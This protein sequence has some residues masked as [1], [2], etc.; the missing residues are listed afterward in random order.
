MNNN[1]RNLGQKSTPDGLTLRRKA[2]AIAVA[3]FVTLSAGPVY[4]ADDQALEDLQKVLQELKAENANLK[5]KLE[6]QTL[7][8]AASSASAETKAAPAD[9]N[10]KAAATE[11]SSILDAVVVKFK[12]KNVLEKIKEVPASVSIVSGEQLENLQATNITEVLRRVGNV[13]FNYGNPRTGSLT[14]RGITTGSSDQIDPSI[15]TVLDGVSIGYTPLVNGYI[16]TDIDT[17]DVTRGPQGTQ[18]AKASNIGRITFTTKP[19]TFSPEASLSQTFGDWNTLKT[20][21]V[22]GGAVVDDLLAWRGTLVREQ[23]DGPFKNQFPDLA[24]RSTYQNVDRTFGRV[25]LLLTPTDNF[26][27]KLSVEDQPKGAEFINGN[28]V[29]HPEPTV[30]SDGVARP[31]A[32]VDTTYKKY[33]NRAWFNADP[34]TWNPATDYFK[35]ATNV[36]NNGAIITGSKGATLNLDWNVAGHNLK[37]ITGYRDH[38]FSAANDE[39]TPFDITKSGGYITKYNQLSQEFRITSDKSKGKFVDYLA[40]VYFL[41]TDNDSNNRTRYGNDAGAFQASDASS[42]TGANATLYG[43]NVTQYNFLASNAAGQALLRDSLNLAYKNTHTYVKNQSTALYGQA[44]WHLSEPLTLTTGYR[45]SNEDRK[46]AQGIFL[47]DKGVGADFNTAFGNVTTSAAINP[48]NPATGSTDQQAAANRLAQKYFGAV[49]TYATLT[50]T[51]QNQLKTAALIRNAT[52]QP[53]SLY[54]TKDATNPW[55]GNINSGNISLANKFNEDF[56]VYG[57]LQYGEKAGISQIDTAGISSLVKK[58]RTTGYELGLRTSFLENALTLNTD[59]FLNDIKDFQSTVNVE[60]PVATA[61]YRLAN[62]SVSAADSQ[63]Y[64]SVVGNVPGVRVK[65][66]EIDATYTGIKNITLTLASAYNDA[67]FSKDNILA[68]P[69][70]IDSTTVPFQKYYNAKG[71]TLNNAPKFTANLGVDYRLPVFGNKVFHSSANYKYTSSQ[72]TSNSSYDV[73]DAYGILDL[74]VG[75]GRKDGLFDLNLI[76]K[77][78]LNTEYHQDAFSS[79]TPTLPRWIGIVFSGKL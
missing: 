15:G 47:A 36:D 6:N 51:Q 53:G 55:K 58:E 19:P 60:D 56:T 66:L 67:R 4:A 8:N 33:L 31:A 49:A 40:G 7:N 2:I 28:T 75:I 43:A 59:V 13:N 42:A 74:G 45:I 72:H 65:G 34:T 78:A 69:S 63:Q 70:E 73:I 77:N 23:A 27:A 52:L 37:S 54:F 46:T 29:R 1:Q 39:G 32:S 18:G 61:A 14:L 21:A 26:T 68:K 50:T 71:E 57:T 48:I 12:K 11:D 38:W 30:F 16:F 25:Q 5:K 76:A 41:D 17:V 64:Q 10:V 35:Y 22:L 44:D 24:G 62:P 79:Y 9:Q 20:S 3:S